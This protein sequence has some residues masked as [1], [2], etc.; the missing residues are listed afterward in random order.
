MKYKYNQFNFL[1]LKWLTKNM[2]AKIGRSS[3]TESCETTQ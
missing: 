3:E 1:Q 2:I